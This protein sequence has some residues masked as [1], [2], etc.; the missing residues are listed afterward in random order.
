MVD[1]NNDE[2]SIK[3]VDQLKWAIF[4]NLAAGGN[5]GV[6]ACPSCCSTG[7]WQADVEDWAFSC[8][9]CHVRVEGRISQDFSAK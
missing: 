6:F 2:A 7:R 8:E 4:T 3:R 1:L 5:S 9:A